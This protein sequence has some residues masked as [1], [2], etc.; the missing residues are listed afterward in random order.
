MRNKKSRLQDCTACSALWTKGTVFPP[1]SCFSGSSFSNCFRTS[2]SNL[3]RSPFWTMAATS[4]LE[5]QGGGAESAVTQRPPS[6][7]TCYRDMYLCKRSVLSLGR[8]TII[9]KKR[10]VPMINLESG[11]GSLLCPKFCFWP[12]SNDSR[13][14]INPATQI[15]VSGHLTTLKRKFN[16]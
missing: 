4:S 14:E 6:T 2:T 10:Y 12:W 8:A 1:T 7:I 3:V 5:L 16:S 13:P 15:F 11:P 9:Q